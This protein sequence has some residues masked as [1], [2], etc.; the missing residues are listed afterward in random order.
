MR[1]PKA[2]LDP[3]SNCCWDLEGEEKKVLYYHFC[4]ALLF[5]PIRDWKLEIL[6]NSGCQSE[7]DLV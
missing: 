3:E 2:H 5:G 1:T 6:W 7:Q 4:T